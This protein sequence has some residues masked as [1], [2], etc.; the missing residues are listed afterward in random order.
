MKVGDKIYIRSDNNRTYENGKMVLEKTFRTYEIT[1][2]T[3]QSWLIGRHK[4]PKKAQLPYYLNS[5]NYTVGEVHNDITKE[6][7]LW[8][9]TYRN[10]IVEII[11]STNNIEA[12]KHI[13][14]YLELNQPNEGK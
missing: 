8:D 5:R 1:G 3:K 7:W 9:K 10:Q 13:K 2:E 6:N 14:Q 4:F 12:L 11:R